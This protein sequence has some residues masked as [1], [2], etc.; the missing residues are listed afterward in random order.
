MEELFLSRRVQDALKRAVDEQSETVAEM[1]RICEIP[2][3][4]FSE[5]LR[6]E[7]VCNRMKELGLEDVRTSEIGNVIGRL[8]GQG[9]GPLV[10]VVAHLDTVFPHGTD[11]Q[12]KRDGNRLLAPGIGDNCS[13]L[14]GMLA[15][16][17]ALI[18]AGIRP[19]GDLVLAA[20]VG[21]EGLGNLRGMRAL[22]DEFDDRASA[23]IALD[24]NLGALVH[25]GVGSRRLKVIC[26]TEG[27]HSWGSFGAP[28]AIHAL[29]RMIDRVSRLDVPASPR[30]T[31]NA[32]LISGGTSVNTIAPRAECLIDLRSVDGQ[33]LAR[34]EGRVR[35]IIQET[36]EETAVRREIEVIGDRPAGMIPADHS[37]VRT[38]KQVHDFLGLETRIMPSSTDMNIPLSRGIPAITVGVTVG[39]NGHRVDE[40]VDVAP[41]AKGVQQ[42][43]LLLV[44]LFDSG[45][46]DKTR[47]GRV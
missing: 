1:V 11:V 29:C 23:V 28:S 21:E 25:Q 43:I 41:L 24:G 13:N 26:R 42:L 46:L 14:A 7:Y 6:G 38:V 39:G 47:P 17:R 33:E 27:G 45:A 31:Y 10:I 12:V 15:A 19:E 36:G 40:Y 30:T 9:G 4:T 22:M 8:P 20:T 44:A 3:P 35:R 18:G 5:G 37:L 16:A 34:L 2:A 32:G